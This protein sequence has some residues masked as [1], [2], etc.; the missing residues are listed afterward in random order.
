M[1]ELCIKKTSQVFN[2]ILLYF[3]YINTARSKVSRK[4][5]E[6]KN[7]QILIKKLRTLKFDYR[8]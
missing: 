6:K 4:K 5:K 3:S 1:F 7:L 2:D 8:Y